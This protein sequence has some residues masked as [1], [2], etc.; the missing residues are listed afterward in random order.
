MMTCQV[1]TQAM[2]ANYYQKDDYYT[3]LINADF[4][5][6]I[7]RLSEVYIDKV[8]SYDF[9]TNYKAVREYIEMERRGHGE[10]NEKRIALDCTFSA[11]KSVSLLLAKDEETRSLI[12][13]LHNKAVDEALKE[14]E[15]KYIETR[16]NG[17]KI[18]TGNML[19][20]KHQ[21][22]ENRNEE[23][24]CHTHCQ[25][26]NITIVDGKEYAIDYGKL[27]K[28]QKELGTIYRGK[29][30]EELQ[31]NGIK[32]EVTD[33]K[34]GFFEVKGFSKEVLEKYSTRRAEIVE[35][36][37]N[38]NLD[39]TS[40]N[41]MSATLK[42]RKPK[43]ATMSLEENL[44]QAHKMIYEKL[45]VKPEIIQMK[46]SVNHEFTAKERSHANDYKDFTDHSGRNSFENDTAETARQTFDA[47]GNGQGRSFEELKT[48][49]RLQNL[50]TGDVDTPT[51]RIDV[52]L[53][54]AKIFNLAKLQTQRNRDIALHKSF[55]TKRRSDIKRLTEKA[56]KDIAQEKF[57]FTIPELRERIINYN[58]LNNVSKEQ[59]QEL[60]EEYGLVKLGVN[61]RQKGKKDIFLTTEE[62]IKTEN[63]ILSQVENGKGKAKG[64]DYENADKLLRDVM[65]EK[66]LTPSEEQQIAVKH[67]LTNNNSIVCVQGLAGVGKTY[68]CNTL[69]ECCEKEDIKIY[70]VCF[71]GKAAA[72]LQEDSKI[73]SGTIHSFLSAKEKESNPDIE[74]PKGEIK[75]SW[76]FSKV[77]KADE[78]EILLVDEAGLVDNNLMKSLI[79]YQE[80]RGENCQIV[81]QGD[82]DQL[83][84]VGAG[85]PMK[86]LI[87][88]G[89]STCYL[90]DIRR[91]KDIE[92]LEAVRESVSGN[93]LKT[94]EK[95][96]KKG[97][98]Q[99]IKDADERKKAIV[100]ELTKDKIEAYKDK[101][102]LVTTNK[103]RNAYNKAIRD[104]FVE[105]GE[106]E[107]GKNFLVGERDENGEQTTKKIKLAVKDQ[108]IFLKN[109]NKLKVKN[110]EL[111][112][113]QKIEGDLITC[114][115]KGKSITFN[116]KEYNNIDYGYSLTNYK[117]QGV[118]IDK[119]VCDMSTTGKPQNRNDL[120]V[121]ISRGKY[122]AKVFT[123][124]KAKLEKQT[125][126]FCEKITGS[127]FKAKIEAMKNGYNIT[128]NDRYTAPK[129][130][131]DLLYKQTEVKPILL[132][133]VVPEYITKAKKAI[134]EQKFIEAEKAKL[135]EQ[136]KEAQRKEEKRKVIEAEK[137]RQKKIAKENEK[138]FE[139]E[140]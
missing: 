73:Q 58:I 120:Y 11:P 130:A 9:N 109:D 121:D 137:A 140:L 133:E 129:N 15:E 94:F 123:D 72:G 134:E 66:K 39:N 36:L 91:Q 102:L 98:Y 77:P 118:S 115:N 5:K 104:V 42:T 128:N 90:T 52:L 6:F 53:P 20:S 10:Q 59:A 32:C 101:L 12:L 87:E 51:A 27:Q 47:F 46:E 18:N 125:M 30:A 79:E 122:E 89:A 16:V 97:N 80:K 81:L 106:L 114:D 78:K 100:E 111:A 124:N 76:D 116:I 96:D 28:R 138:Q 24:N 68:M 26:Y 14:I 85:E 103:A 67:I 33:Y 1:V 69:R 34:K 55:A 127:D 37:N 105:R 113:I 40:K 17:K 83:P 35:Y 56:I 82:Y 71:T 88:K 62:N 45:K 132:K 23:L 75:Q 65:N 131:K 99:E 126:E 117:A 136:L 21:H 31:K 110:G 4:D 22:F 64:I 74:Q 54:N 48:G 29:L 3:K 63:Y 25:I 119:V 19:C 50:L 49:N 93:T 60:I 86:K 8:N 61:E 13:K 135:R 139:F 43:K 44:K 108:I 38:N 70:G 107:K 7:G 57:A 92:L 2:T 112:T 95:L 41:A 84:A